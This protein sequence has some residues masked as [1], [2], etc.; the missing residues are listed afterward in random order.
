MKHCLIR[1]LCLLLCAVLT[2]SLLPHTAVFAGYA[3]GWY[4][5]GMAGDDCGIYAHGVDLS[6]WQGHEVDFNQIR[7]QGYSFVILR[8][9]FAATKDDAFEENYAR[10]KAAGLDVGV[11]LY[12]Y[13]D[14]PE[15][16]LRES[17]AL[18]VWLSGKQLEYPVYFD[19]EDPNIHA[20]M[21]AEALTALALAFLDDMAAD[22]W[23][24]GL[25]SCKS[26]LDNKLETEKI[27]AR[28]ECWMA[29][30]LSDGTY[31]IYD[32][33]D[34]MYGMWQYSSSAG[35]EGVPGTADVN[36][37]FKDY[38]AICRQFGFNGYAATGEVLTLN[39]MS[40]PAVM[41]RGEMFPID[42]T[43]VSREG[44]LTNVT[45]GVYDETGEMVTGRSAGPRTSSFALSEL[46]EGVKLK[47]LA[48][49]RY[50]LR[51]TATNTS[52][53]RTL[54]KQSLAV[55]AAGVR[56]D[57]MGVPQ[58]LK[59]GDSFA[60]TGRLLASTPLKQVKVRVL[61]ADGAERCSLT[62]VPNAAEFDL[63]SLTEPLNTSKLAAGGYTYR[64]EAVTEKGSETLLSSDFTVW[65]RN[66]PITLTGFSLRSEYRP[67]ELSGLNGVV[68]SQFSPLR[69]V[70]VTV[71]DR[72]GEIVASAQTERQKK[73]V[74][75]TEFRKAL[76]LETL[77]AGSYTCRIEALNAGGPC[78]V[79]EQSFLLRADA[80]SLCELSA[81]VCLR[82]G[83]AFLLDGAV[84]SEESQLAYVGVTV[85]D[86][87]GR[88]VL[89]AGTAPQSH[90][91]DLRGLG[92]GLLFS[93]L[94]SGEYTLR[95]CA[96][97]G[98]G[99]QTLYEERFTVTQSDDRVLWSGEHFYLGGTT[100]YAGDGICLWGTIVSEQSPLTKV[101][102][103]ITDAEGRFVTGA[104]KAVDG[105]SFGVAQ[106]GEMLR[107]S[108][109]PKGE[110]RLRIKA[111][112]AN[113]ETVL[114]NEHFAVT[115]CPHMNVCSGEVV[116]ATCTA[117]GAICDSRCLD[118]G[119]KVRN[120]RLLEMRPHDFRDGVCISCGKS[121]YR[122]VAVRPLRGELQKNGRYVLAYI[123]GDAVYALGANGETQ[124]IVFSAENGSAAVSAELL[125]TPVLKDGNVMCF[126]NGREQRLHLDSSAIS[127]GAG[128]MNSVLFAE[129]REEGYLLRLHERRTRCLSFA[130]GDFSVGKIPCEIT[131][132]EYIQH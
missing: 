103:E 127:V 4:A 97:N 131:F 109:L 75:L 31:N 22:G 110:Y 28:Y 81:P 104:H 2:V 128:N 52:G 93:T 34:G 94:L 55:S 1:F 20:K 21:S 113:G 95:I 10:A 13:A 124:Q 49:G 44:V 12:S 35:V 74:L 38:P 120:G 63:T 32:R 5:G 57:E 47:S 6:N 45:V 27:C 82:E 53:T 76:S 130:D 89:D 7:A 33:Y 30:Y 37:C 43:V 87:K 56:C 119:A 114:C 71:L 17:A 39:G 66:D 29:Q 125:W 86:E 100:F 9:G 48:A 67:Q 91:C 15:A 24:V 68:A 88:R 46:A 3:E 60:P 40:A 61:D 62:A 92:E 50:E 69:C 59:E 129:R 19:M 122:T 26:W 98:E 64:V 111:E 126:V 14:S 42:G 58:D 51:V 65:V 107:F 108:A 72:T 11:Y 79:A 77:P 101:T 25:Y 8:A 54:L 18:K 90:F 112:N 73:Q 70:S 115:D 80:M 117:R 16:V 132:F 121:D 84:T 118:C 106:F 99:Y 36:V 23:L 96:E 83:D 41:V 85:T 123:D 105:Q 116:A 78:L 102:A